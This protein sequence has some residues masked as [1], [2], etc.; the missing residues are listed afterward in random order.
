MKSYN[1]GWYVDKLKRGERFSLARYGDGE[2]YCMWGR[3]GHNSNG[4]RYSTELRE[5]LVKSMCHFRDETFIYGMQRVLPRDR[6]RFEKDYPCIEFNNSEIFSEAVANG[7]LY[8]LIEQL[9]KMKCVLIGNNTLKPVAEKVLN[10]VFF[11]IPPTNSY[12]IANV[13]KMAVNEPGTVYLFSAGMGANAIIGELHGSIDCWMIDLGHIWDPF[14]G[15]MSRC[16]L[17]GKTK[18][19]IE[20]N[21]HEKIE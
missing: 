16:D 1:L 10:C 6:E 18:E 2:M 15:L 4:C 19:E 11:E 7:E 13:I 14:V 5:S 20:K 12:D 3:Q 21:L 9:R 8:P 17:E